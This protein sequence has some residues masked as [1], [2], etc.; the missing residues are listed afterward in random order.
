MSIGTQNSRITA[1][2][3]GRPVVA[4]LS[5]AA[6]FLLIA[7]LTGWAASTLDRTT[8]DRVYDPYFTT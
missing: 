6:V 5:L 1:V 2:E 7:L 8:L 3:S 4:A